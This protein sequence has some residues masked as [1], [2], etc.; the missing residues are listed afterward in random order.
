MQNLLELY[1]AVILD[2]NRNPRNFRSLPAANAQGRG[3][4]PACGDQYEVFLRIEKDT[5]AEVAFQ[6]SGCAISRASASVL[7]TELTG[8]TKAG[9][10]ESIKAFLAVIETGEVLESLPVAMAAFSGIHKFPARRKCAM[11]AW[12]AAMQ[13]L[14]EANR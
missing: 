13:A 7:T 2:H 12:K 1:Q 14:E 6:G 3:E 5:L 4:N 10:K 8:Q 9:A 11:L